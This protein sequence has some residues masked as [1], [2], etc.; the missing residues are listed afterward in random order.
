[1]NWEPITESE[2]KD[3]ILQAET[4][5][6]P[7]QSRL[8]STIKILPQQWQQMT[9][10]SFWV[11]AII[12]ELVLWFN[13]IEEGFNVSHYKKYGEIEEYWCNQDQLEWAVQSLLDILQQGYTSPKLGPPEA[14]EY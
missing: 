10:G 6:E 8:W 12:G 1:M 11:V 2:L 4:R 9:Y 5:M 7:P 3:M 13:D 14:L